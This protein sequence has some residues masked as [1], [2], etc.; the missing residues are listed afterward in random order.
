MILIP[1][2]AYSKEVFVARNVARSDT[3]TQRA[4]VH[5]DNDVALRRLL[6]G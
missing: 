1:V 5:G 6:T 2:F 3:V 4:F